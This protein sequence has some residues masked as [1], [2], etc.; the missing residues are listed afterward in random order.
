MFMPMLGVIVERNVFPFLLKLEL[1]GRR[2]PLRQGGLAVQ[3][4][5]KPLRSQHGLGMNAGRLRKSCI[6]RE[7]RCPG[8]LTRLIGEYQELLFRLNIKPCSGSLSSGG[9]QSGLLG[10]LPCGSRSCCW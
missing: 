4:M 7:W 1:G 3:L 10:Q 8:L 6:P 5:R 2:Q 9:L